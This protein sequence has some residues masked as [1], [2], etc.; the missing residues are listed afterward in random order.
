[1]SARV[2]GGV[3]RY[4]VSPESI[5]FG[6]FAFLSSLS[7]VHGNFFLDHF[8]LLVPLVSLYLVVFVVFFHSSHGQGA[9]TCGQ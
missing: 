1:M 2:L 6:R 4:N 7:L 3:E 9:G 5:L 8:L